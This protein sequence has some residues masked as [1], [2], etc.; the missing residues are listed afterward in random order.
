MKKLRFVALLLLSAS[1]S[2]L[3]AQGLSSID[4]DLDRLESLIADTLLNTEEQQRLLEDLRQ[5]LNESG[6]LID[7]YESTITWQEKSLKD[8]QT[9]LSEMSEIYMTQSASSAKYE[10]SLKRW[11]TFTLIGIPSAALLSGG[12]VWAIGQ[13]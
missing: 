5:A 6:N 3:P 2:A 8:L 12:L 1:L 9:R 13:K 7:S 4:S 10:K 11:K